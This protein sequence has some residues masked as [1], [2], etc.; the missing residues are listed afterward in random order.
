M[1]ILEQNK[2]KWLEQLSTLFVHAQLLTI[3]MYCTTL[4]SYNTLNIYS[5][6]SLLPFLFERVAAE[7]ASIIRPTS[8]LPNYEIWLPEWEVVLMN[9]GN[10]PPH[11]LRPIG[12]Q[13]LQSLQKVAERWISLRSLSK[14]Y[15]IHSHLTGEW[16]K[17]LINPLNKKKGSHHPG[18]WKSDLFMNTRLFMAVLSE[19]WTPDG[20]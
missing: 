7:W 15:G 11:W 14:S 20:P 3:M 4:L 13:R 18:T 16:K 8:R 12:P 5:C 9:S 2:K 19:P 10:V 17:L 6:C 1:T